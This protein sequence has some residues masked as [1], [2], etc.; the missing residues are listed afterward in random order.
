MPPANVSEKISAEIH[1]KIV[2]FRVRS[3]ISYV[4]VLMQL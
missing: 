4:A 3:Y 1:P 2:P